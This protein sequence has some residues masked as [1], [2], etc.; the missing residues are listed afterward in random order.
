[1][2]HHFI[3]NGSDNKSQEHVNNASPVISHKIRTLL[4]LAP[5]YPTVQYAEDI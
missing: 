4:R 2:M 5:P 1:M 3:L